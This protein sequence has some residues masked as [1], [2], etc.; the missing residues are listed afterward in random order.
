MPGFLKNV[1][2]DMLHHHMRLFSWN[3]MFPSGYFQLNILIQPA[4]ALISNRGNRCNLA[5][6]ISRRS[7][8]SPAST[9]NECVRACVCVCVY[10]CVCVCRPTLHSS[11]TCCKLGA[12]ATHTHTSTRKEVLNAPLPVCLGPSPPQLWP[13][14]EQAGRQRRA[15]WLS[16]KA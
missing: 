1:C 5:L 7:R 16:G 3:M 9:R 15:T 14:T 8:V 12:L 2:I 10:V 6:V 13:D 11:I 4:C